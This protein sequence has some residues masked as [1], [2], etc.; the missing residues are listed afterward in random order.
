MTQRQEG[1]EDTDALSVP[2]TIYTALSRL[3]LLQPPPIAE[4][5]APELRVL[6]LGAGFKEGR[7]GHS[8]S[9]IF[10]PMCA[11]AHA[12][13]FA[14]LTL[15]LVGTECVRGEG[16][17]ATAGTCFASERHASQPTVVLE[18]AWV[19]GKYM[20]VR[21]KPD[22]AL[23]LRTVHAF[24]LWHEEGADLL[25]LLQ[26]LDQGDSD[27]HSN[28]AADA[29][30]GSCAE[31]VSNGEKLTDDIVVAGSAAVDATESPA[32]FHLAACL[33][34]GVWGYET[35]ADTFR[36]L[37][38]LP[39]PSPFPPLHRRRTGDGSS[40]SVT[41][42]SRAHEG[43]TAPAAEIEK[44][45]TGAATASAPSPA[46]HGCP[47]LVTS[48]NRMEAESDF[49]AVAA[50]SAN[51]RI[52]KGSVV[53]GAEKSAADAGFSWIWEEEENPFRARRQRP[54]LHEGQVLA[55]NSHW[56]CFH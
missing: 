29:T 1:G 48:Y 25:D 26:R 39:P 3:G 9:R 50:M 31:S 33:N 21:N 18:R 55:D 30:D 27:R 12:R 42:P 36:A 32:T 44:N 41:A 56:Q 16:E 8:T 10:S 22:S 17:V 54:S 52:E 34:A 45:P 5:K 23:V 51:V 28:A 2:F 37:R 6:L 47:I 49:D 20:N 14:R 46:F 19:D 13:G 40:S 4:S 35:W 38:S 7:D 43:G 53:G 24:G 11:L 15:V